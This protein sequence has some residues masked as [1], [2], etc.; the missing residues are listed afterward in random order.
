MMVLLLLR[1][2]VSL[3]YLITKCVRQPEYTDCYQYPLQL[4]YIGGLLEYGL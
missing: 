2:K 4:I 1:G 3:E